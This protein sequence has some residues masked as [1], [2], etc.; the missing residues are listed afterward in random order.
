[1]TKTY[2]Q[3]CERRPIEVG[4][5]VNYRAGPPG[6]IESQA[7][8]IEAI[9]VWVPSLHGYIEVN[10]AYEWEDGDE[11]HLT[12]FHVYCPSSTWRRWGYWD[13]VTVNEGLQRID[14]IME[15]TNDGATSTD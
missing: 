14:Q 8:K 11:A 7:M 6:T 10:G 13:Q 12:L 2:P 5:W 3:V 4:Q 9:E 1:M 15:E